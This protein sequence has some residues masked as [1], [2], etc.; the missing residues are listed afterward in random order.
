[1]LKSKKNFVIVCVLL[2]AHS[3]LST[4]LMQTSIALDFA[5]DFFLAGCTSV[6]NTFCALHAVHI[7]SQII[8]IIS[9]ETKFKVVRD[10]KC[11]EVS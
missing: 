5:F 6:Y 8:T 10:F 11:S 2:S 9:T 4:I 1:M 3:E 7:K